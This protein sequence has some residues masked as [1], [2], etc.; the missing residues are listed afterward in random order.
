MYF[1][2]R[3]FLEM[4]PIFDPASHENRTWFC[5]PSPLSAFFLFS[6]PFFSPCDPHPIPASSW[7]KVGQDSGFP[8]LMGWDDVLEKIGVR[9]LVL[10]PR[11]WEEGKGDGQAHQ[12]LPAFLLSSCPGLAASPHRLFPP[13]LNFSRKLKGEFL[14]PTGKLTT[15][16]IS[17]I[18]RFC[19][20]GSWKQ[21]GKLAFTLWPGS[22]ILEGRGFYSSLQ[23]ILRHSYSD[24]GGTG[25]F[26]ILP[27]PA[28]LS[29]AFLDLGGIFGE[30][31]AWSR[32]PFSSES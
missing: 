21:K 9:P 15:F 17:P 24:D 26:W 16:Y 19:N 4:H 20:L 27:S 23:L 7:E 32:R 3:A 2:L 6:L 12:K 18:L 13:C 28:P 22:L 25:S 11:I 30:L 31:T 14:E 5:L 29:L 8:G 10:V 1:N